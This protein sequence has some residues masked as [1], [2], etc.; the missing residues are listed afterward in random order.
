[1]FGMKSIRLPFMRRKKADQELEYLRD[2]M[3]RIRELSEKLSDY[4]SLLQLTN[5]DATRQFFTLESGG[6]ETMGLFKE[7]IAAV[8]ITAFYPYTSF[9]L[10]FHEEKEVFI[11]LCGEI[12]F[13]TA[14]TSK[15]LRAGD[16]FYVEAGQPH[17]A[18]TRSGCRILAVTIPA[19]KDWPD[20]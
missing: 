1:M 3:V 2:N 10:H 14:E 4:K 17:R 11:C 20:A 5:E 12:E 13:Y 19:A 6:G 7:P 9:P 16:I 8:A 15:T 18:V